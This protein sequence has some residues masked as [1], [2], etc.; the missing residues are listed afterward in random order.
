MLVAAA[1]GTIISKLSTASRLQGNQ[2]DEPY[3]FTL[4]FTKEQAKVQ[5]LE[6]RAPLHVWLKCILFNQVVRIRGWLDSDRTYESVRNNSDHSTTNGSHKP[7]DSEM[8]CPSVDIR[9]F[10]VYVNVGVHKQ[11]CAHSAVYRLQYSFKK[12]TTMATQQ[13]AKAHTTRQQLRHPYQEMEEHIVVT[14]F[15]CAAPRASACVRSPRR[16]TTTAL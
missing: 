6:L 2:Q 14:L 12:C 13:Q 4:A 5:H 11:D 10:F 8:R 1:K 16:S 15:L 3:Q 7:T 9:S